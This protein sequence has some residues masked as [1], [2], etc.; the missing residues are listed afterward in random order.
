[1][2]LL[3]CVALVCFSLAVSE[4]LD[5]KDW[6]TTDVS[7][8]FDAFTEI[9]DGEKGRFSIKR[10]KP[11]TGELI[12]DWVHDCYGKGDSCIEYRGVEYMAL[13]STPV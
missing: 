11:S 1:M 2:H 9:V 4:V 12:E 3:Y 6:R 10:L 7:I 13:R 8:T 5:T